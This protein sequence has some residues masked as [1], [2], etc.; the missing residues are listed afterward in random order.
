VH[1]SGK[2]QVYDS[3]PISHTG[4]ISNKTVLQGI[5]SAEDRILV[6]ESVDVDNNINNDDNIDNC[7]MSSRSS[8]KVIIDSV[9]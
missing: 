4:S 9:K 2:K 3:I 7:S 5:F 8:V 1:Q 6:K